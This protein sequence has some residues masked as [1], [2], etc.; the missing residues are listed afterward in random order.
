MAAASPACKPHLLKSCCRACI[1]VLPACPWWS[2][3]PCL[4]CREDYGGVEEYL[5]RIG[6]G[7]EAQQR[8]ARALT[9]PRLQPP[10][11]VSSI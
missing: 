9:A 2:H 8:L 1:T 6:F 5:T 4:C 7:P 11:A 10:T 3:P